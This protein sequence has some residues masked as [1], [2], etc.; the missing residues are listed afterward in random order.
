MRPSCSSPSFSSSPPSDTESDSSLTVQKGRIGK[1]AK[2]RRERRE[3]MAKLQKMVPAS[4]DCKSQLELLQHVI[5]YIFALQEQ[6]RRY[7]AENNNLDKD[8]NRLS[9][10]FSR[11][12]TESTQSILS[13]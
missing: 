3:T 12:S 4:K 2:E 9:S 11:I 7:D 5:D 8:I 13:N 6:L 10:L 1:I